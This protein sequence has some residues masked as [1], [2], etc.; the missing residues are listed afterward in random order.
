MSAISGRLL[1]SAPQSCS[2]RASRI[3]HTKT[4]KRDDQREDRDERATPARYTRA[5]Q[6]VH[7]PVHQEDED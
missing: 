7:Q 4:M 6:P 5:L 1:M 3:S 2:I